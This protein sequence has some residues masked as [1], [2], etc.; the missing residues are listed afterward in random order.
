MDEQEVSA[1]QK[2][3]LEIVNEMARRVHT[4]MCNYAQVLTRKTKDGT[5]TAAD[6]NALINGA[7]S[8]IAVLVARM[9]ITA[10][11][12]VTADFRPPEEYFADMLK[13][14]FIMTYRQ[15]QQ[16]DSAQAI[17]EGAPVN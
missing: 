2:A 16:L 11:P 14:Q 4:V 17:G 8:G 15:T 13:Q 7:V 3:Q 9:A 10:N 1:E 6:S 12:A 5:V